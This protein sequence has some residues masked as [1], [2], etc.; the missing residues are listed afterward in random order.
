MPDTID[1]KKF[2]EIYAE[3]P[4]WDIDG[5][6]QPFRGLAGKLSGSLLD[7]GCGSGENALFFAAQ[8]L[9]VTGIDF[10]E[11]PIQQAR[12]KAAERG[13]DVNF[14]VKDALTLSTWGE[15]FNNVLDSGLFHVFSDQ[16]RATYVSGLATVLASSG[17]LFLLCFSER[18]PGT[19]GPRRVTRPELG[20]AFAGWTI[21]S[22]ETARFEVRPEFKQKMFDGVDPEGWFVTVRRP[23]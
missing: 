13:L 18:T 15:R 17:R 20:S 6:Q 14:L 2:E 8:G 7:S 11:A 22:V 3:R 1:K 19:Q 16:D 23:A 4:P 5:A 12:C 10:V 21:E 9:K